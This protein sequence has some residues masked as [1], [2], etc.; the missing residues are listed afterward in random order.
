MIGALLLA[1]ALVAP[2]S[3][4]DPAKTPGVV[5]TDLTLQAICAT[6]WG[7]DERHVTPA[8][9]AEVFREYGFTGPHDPAFKPDAAG[10]RVEID[11]LISRELG[12]ADAVPNLWPEAR[13][14]QPFNADLKD[15]IENRLHVEVCAGR[16]SLEDA[17]QMMR[18]DWTAAYV[19]FFGPPPN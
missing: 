15:R 18:T 6:K 1:A 16:L 9:K 4:P 13:A 12:G 14:T 5:R 3:M 11:H 7:K 19:K 10:R 2:P 8:M 17:Q